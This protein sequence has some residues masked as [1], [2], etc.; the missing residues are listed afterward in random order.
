MQQL[1]DYFKD[2]ILAPVREW[3]LEAATNKEFYFGAK[4]F[5]FVPT[6][7]GHEPAACFIPDALTPGHN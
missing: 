6:L 4:E 1:G 2:R 5:E 7:L 3:Q